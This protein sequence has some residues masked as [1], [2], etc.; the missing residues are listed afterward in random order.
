MKLTVSQS[1]LLGIEPPLWLTTS[2]CFSESEMFVVI[3]ITD[4]GRICPVSS[5][6]VFFKYRYL[7]YIH[8]GYCK[9]KG[10]VNYYLICTLYNHRQ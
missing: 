8:C 3:T 2:Y 6:L 9:R 7:M 1:I 10:T 4:R 5:A